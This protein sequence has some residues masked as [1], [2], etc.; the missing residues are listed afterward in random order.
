MLMLQANFVKISLM[1]AVSMLGLD[2]H[3]DTLFF[4]IEL[5]ETILSVVS[6][7]QVQCFDAVG[8]AAGRATGLQLTEWWGTGT[9]ICL[10]RGANEVQRMV[11]LMQLPYHHLLLQ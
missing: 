10:E 11:Q 9:V 4:K 5:V 8:W 1:H 6:C 2:M 7:C 3:T